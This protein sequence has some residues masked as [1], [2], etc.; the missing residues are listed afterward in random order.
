MK[1]IKVYIIISLFLISIVLFSGC[2][3]NGSTE[4]NIL[5][6]WCQEHG[7][8]DWVNAG[9]QCEFEK[10]IN[11]TYIYGVC[12]VIIF[13]NATII[14][15]VYYDTYNIYFRGYCPYAK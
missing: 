6:K 2:V 12:D 3:T 1:H 15:S 5:R 8:T 13:S 14:D 10:T 9:A 11:D 7:G 4:G